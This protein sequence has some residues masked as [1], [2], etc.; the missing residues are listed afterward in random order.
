[1]D[2]FYRSISGWFD[3]DDIY[4]SVVRASQSGA[5]FV[6]VGSYLGR[7]A[8]FMCVEIAKSG[9]DVRF[10]CVDLWPCSANG[11]SEY[12]KFRENMKPV[13]GLF[14]PVR[15]SSVEASKLY[16]DNSLDFVFIDAD[17][18]YEGV[19]ADILHWLPKVKT[20]GV[21]AGHDFAH[22]CP[23]V[24]KAVKE[25]P[26]SFSV[27]RNSWF[28]SVR[29]QLKRTTVQKVRLPGLASR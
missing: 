3:F 19:K 15:M 9:K 17:H 24:M 7:S 11:E 4:S 2:H 18:E 28:C 8:A 1:M 10:D 25:L 29:R 12:D 14:A 13:E 23:G 26:G 27:S 16:E 21:L 20:N 6:E 5:K 22:Y